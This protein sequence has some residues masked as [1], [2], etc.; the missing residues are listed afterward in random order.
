MRL[1]QIDALLSAE[2]RKDPLDQDRGMIAR[3]Q[4][5]R[6][7]LRRYRPIEP[8]SMRQAAGKG[9]EYKFTFKNHGDKEVAALTWVY[10]F[11]D[12]ATGHEVGRLEFS[13]K[14]TLPPGKER[15]VT[16]YSDSSPPMVVN[17]GSVKKEGKAWKELVTVES[18][19]FS[20]GS[21][22]QSSR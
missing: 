5:E 7:R 10:I 9:Y 21:T 18:V 14:V 15:G 22:A 1:A 17:V 20:D 8:D 6:E 2:Y 16:A 11:I 12:S 19:K 3:L 4:E 13:S